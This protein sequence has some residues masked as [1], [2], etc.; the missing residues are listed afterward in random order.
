[1]RTRQFPPSNSPA[2][3]AAS[4]ARACLVLCRCAA[5]T[6]Q[7]GRLPDEAIAALAKWV[8]MGAPWPEAKPVTPDDYRISP[9]QKRFWSFQPVRRPPLPAVKNRGWCRTPIDA[10]ILAGLEK[11]GL[12]P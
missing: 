12:A 2:S 7:A 4:P 6:P 9:P 8:R 3:L 5:A 1:M 11:R 10:F